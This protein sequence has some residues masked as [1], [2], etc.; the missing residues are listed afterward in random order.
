MMETLIVVT[1]ALLHVK[2]KIVMSH[3]VQHALQTIFVLIAL[4]LITLSM[5]LV[6]Y[7]IKAAHVMVGFCQ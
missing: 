7:A 1:D 3:I 4:H 5:D 6:I 2:Y